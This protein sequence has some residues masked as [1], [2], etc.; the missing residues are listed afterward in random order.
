MRVNR[1]ARALPHLLGPKRKN[2]NAPGSRDD[3]YTALWNYLDC[4]AAVFPVTHVDRARDVPAPAHAFRNHE[5]EA[6]YRMCESPLVSPPPS[7]HIR[8]CIP[9]PRSTSPERPRPPST[10]DQ[11]EPRAPCHG[12]LRPRCWMLAFSDSGV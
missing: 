9:G 2:A 5:D 4:T 6:V 7:V 10:R 8:A 3:F 12:Q 1:T 11:V